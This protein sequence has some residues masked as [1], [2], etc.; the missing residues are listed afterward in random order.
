MVLLASTLPSL[1][2][3]AQTGTAVIVLGIRSVEGDDE[4]ARN[5]TGALRH[6]ASQVDGWRV[7][8]REVM[9]TQLSLAY[10]CDEP[11]PDCLAEMATSLGVQ[12]LIYGDVRRTSSGQQFDFALQLHVFNAQSGQIEHSVADTISGQRRD[13]DDLREPV[14][15]Y[16]AQLSGAPRAGSLRI[17]VNVPGA[18]VF[19][20]G[21]SVGTADADGSLVVQSVEAG[22]RNIRI[23]AP[24]HRGF[25]STISVEAFGES[26]FEAELEQ[27]V[28][29]DAPTGGGIDG[30]LILGISLLGGGAVFGALWIYSMAHILELQND[31]VYQTWRSF[32]SN[33][34][35]HTRMN[36]NTCVEIQQNPGTFSGVEEVRAI[37]NEA[38]TFEAL[39]WVFLG[40]GAAAAGVGSYFLVSAL[41]G[42]SASSQGAFMLLPSFGPDHAYLAGRLTF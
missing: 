13:I 39:Q 21:E 4:F 26:T 27:G 33:P 38:G 31:S 8:D 23:T 35:Q 14:R 1:V 25:R 16:V 40:L 32:G 7:S 42:S 2:A 36:D 41:T 15:R 30:G 17:S 29:P 5:L 10:G 6:A 12:R 3:S 9:L 11:N 18:E 24:G 28:D 20:D 22:N 19:I 34:M 37:C